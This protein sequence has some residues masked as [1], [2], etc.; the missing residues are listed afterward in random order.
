[1]DIGESLVHHCSMGENVI[2]KIRGVGQSDG[3][4]IAAFE[5]TE[6]GRELMGLEEDTLFLDMLSLQG[7]IES[8]QEKLVE[9]GKNPA[10]NMSLGLLK[11]G[12][13]RLP[14]Y[15]LFKQLE[16]GG[17]VSKFVQ[18]HYLKKQDAHIAVFK[19]SKAMPDV[20]EKQN[21]GYEKNTLINL[22]A[23]IKR[24][25]EE[26]GKS[27]QESIDYQV[28]LQAIRAFPQYKAELQAEYSGS[29]QVHHSSE[30]PEPPAP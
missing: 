5:M 2:L 27:V 23:G 19:P 3:R 21:I 4:P 26:Q 6:D 11:Q 14:D 16:N 22:V 18:W 30:T 25:L 9:S 7:V 20:K 28:M 1:M 12:L 8:I 29:R 10:E 24:I 13:E 17:I 15:Q